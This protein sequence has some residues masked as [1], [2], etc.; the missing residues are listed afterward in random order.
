MV[1]TDPQTEIKTCTSEVVDF[2]N[3]ISNLEAPVAA[4]PEEV[5][6][7]PI[8]RALELSSAKVEISAEGRKSF[9]ERQFRNLGT[10]RGLGVVEVLGLERAEDYFVWALGIS[11]QM[12]MPKLNRDKTA[13]EI[14]RARGL[15]QFMASVAG[16]AV[17]AINREEFTT[18][19]NQRVYNGLVVKAKQ[20]GI[21]E[22][23]IDTGFPGFERVKKVSSVPPGRLGEA[24]EKILEQTG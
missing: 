13:E 18:E 3:R 24:F 7:G 15:M 22:I 12:K 23:K 8:K 11:R 9:R 20:L 6:M 21:E 5:P 1:E 17:G 4:K 2:L 10:G 19:L 14:S 16:L